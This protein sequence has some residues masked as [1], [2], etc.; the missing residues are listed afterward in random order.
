MQWSSIDKEFQTTRKKL[1]EAKNE[2]DAEVGL[3]NV[4]TQRLRHLE[5]LNKVST[6]STSTNV[7]TV[8]NIIP[9]RNPMFEGRINELSKLHSDLEPSF[10]P[11]SSERSQCFCVIHG[12]GGM[13]KTQTALEYV[14]RYRSCY[15]YIFW[16]HAES[17]TAL[18]D[19]FLAAMRLLPIAVDGLSPARQRQA[20]LEYLQST[21]KTILPYHAN[22]IANFN[23]SPMAGSLR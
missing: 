17:N 8:T 11:R 1:T 21:R 13:G 22:E 3:A 16:C 20:G 19:S 23:S 10:S 15:N 4:Q 9:S 18:S 12:V 2:F 6:L 7:A 5:M 14:Y